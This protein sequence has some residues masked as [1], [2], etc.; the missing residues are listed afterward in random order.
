[1]S[2]KDAGIEYAPNAGEAPQVFAGTA[3]N[4]ASS[5]LS[6]GYR[7]AWDTISPTYTGVTIGNGTVVAKFH[8]NYSRVHC[9]WS[10]T[11]GTTSA[12]TGNIE[13][14]FGQNY[15]GYLTGYAAA[16]DTSASRWYPLAWFTKDAG[17][18]VMGTHSSSTSPFTW[19]TGDI[20]AAQWTAR[21]FAESLTGL[22]A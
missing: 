3:I 10:L 15:V 11:L 9:R 14:D 17:L 19:G 4:D 12:V 6:S 5:E 1:M 8:D 7:T 16:F 2:W 22:R 20:I 13:V 21:L 18:D